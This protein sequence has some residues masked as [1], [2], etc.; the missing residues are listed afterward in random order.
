MTLLASGDLSILSTAGTNRSISQEVDRN[1][2]AP[3]TLNGLRG[4]GL[5]TALPVQMSDFYSHTQPYIDYGSITYTVNSSTHVDAYRPVNLVNKLG[6]QWTVI[7]YGYV[8][9]LDSTSTT[10]LY[11]RIAGGSWINFLSLPSGGG[12]DNIYKTITMTSSNTLDVRINVNNENANAARG[13]INIYSVE[14]NGSTRIPYIGT[15]SLWT[16]DI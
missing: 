14:D 2:T 8:F 15:L 12:T 3:K 1:V 13:I 9:S 7:L 16:S 10:D 4:N 6:L 11:Y 5:T